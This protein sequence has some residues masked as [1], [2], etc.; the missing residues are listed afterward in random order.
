[1]L[2]KSKSSKNK[3]YAAGLAVTFTLLVWDSTWGFSEYYTQTSG[4]VEDVFLAIK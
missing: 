1:V 3:E 4:Y 2:H